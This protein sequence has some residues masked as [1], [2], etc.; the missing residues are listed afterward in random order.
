MAKLSDNEEERV[1]NALRHMNNLIYW[2]NGYASVNKNTFMG[3]PRVGLNATIA[4]LS[5][6]LKDN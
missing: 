2:V 4:I 5:D 3:P 6:L 1:K